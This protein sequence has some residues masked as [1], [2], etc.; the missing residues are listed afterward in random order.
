MYKLTTPTKTLKLDYPKIMGILNVTP[1]S[2][3]DGG[4]Y[5]SID[6]ALL[7]VENMILA[8]V[9]II[10]I[11]GE[12]TR[13][14]ANTVSVEEELERTIPVIEAIRTRFDIWLSIDTSK[15]QV[16]TESA[17]AGIDLINDVRAL[18]LPGAREAAAKT[19]LPICLMHH[20][21]EPS[22]MQN[23]PSYVNVIAEVIDTLQEE[24]KLAEHAG[25]TRDRLLIDPGFGF[26]KNNEHNFRLLNELEAFRKFNLPLLVGM[27]RKR[28]IQYALESLIPN[29]QA[30]DRTHG[31]VGAAVIAAMKGAHIIRVHDVAQTAQAL[32]ILKTMKSIN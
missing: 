28:M 15:P 22:T 9:D 18:S 1:D 10:D 26:G 29:N 14:G 8:G 24:I 7:Q 16:M 25:I 12:S 4:N 32:S 30:S 6:K 27:S 3:S 31:S 19:Q 20:K 5:T 2:F 13:P 17:K 11:G 23:N 21:G